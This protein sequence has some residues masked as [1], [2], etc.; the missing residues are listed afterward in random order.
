MLPPRYALQPGA[1]LVQVQPNYVSAS[2]GQIGALADGTPVLA[3]YL[4]S[5]QTGLHTGLTQYQGFA[6]YPGSYGQQLANYSVSDA[7]TYFSGIAAK[8]DTGEASLPADAGSLTFAVLQGL[9]NSSSSLSLEGKGNVLTAA[10]TGGA[11]ALVNISAPNLEITTAQGVAGQAP[12]AVSGA[13]LQSLNASQLGPGRQL[14]RG[15]SL[16][17][18]HARSHDGDRV[19]RRRRFRR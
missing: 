3:G 8:A 1:L 10:A 13:A 14:L 17:G 2:G 11:G 15:R 6:I 18:R 19:Q 7:S 5:G 9:N 16:A 12:S 4:S